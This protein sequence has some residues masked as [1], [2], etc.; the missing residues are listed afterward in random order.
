MSDIQ[1][2]AERLLAVYDAHEMESLDCDRS[3]EYY[4]DCFH[5][6]VEKFRLSVTGKDK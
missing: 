5:K 4:C 1:E 6:A 3:G 2:E